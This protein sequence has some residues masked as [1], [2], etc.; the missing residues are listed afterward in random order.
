MYIQIDYNDDYFDGWT[1]ERER[2]RGE[3]E[4]SK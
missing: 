4:D 1:D 2:E 3:Y